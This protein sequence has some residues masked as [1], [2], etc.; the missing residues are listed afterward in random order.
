[1]KVNNNKNN[2]KNGK[3]SQ[4]IKKLVGEVEVERDTHEIKKVK[5][6][7]APRPRRVKDYDSEKFTDREKL[8]AR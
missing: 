7:S 6:L 2:K 4:D 8:L 1:M 5:K 3:N